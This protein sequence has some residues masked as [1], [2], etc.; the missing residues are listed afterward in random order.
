MASSSSSSSEK[1]D[2]FISFRG[3]D[4]R[5]GLTSFLY[6][7]LRNK[8]IQAYMDVR[9]FET[10]DEISP[11]L[12][13]A[14]KSSKISVVIFSENYASSTWCLNELVQILECQKTNRQIVVPVFYKIDAFMVREQTESYAV[15]F[16]KH[17]ERFKDDIEKVNQ[18]RKALKDATYLH[19]LDSKEYRSGPMLVQKIVD[20]IWLQLPKKQISNYH[21]KGLFGIEERVNKIQRLLSIG[22]TD[23]RII[24]ICGMGGIGSTF[25]GDRFRRKKVLIVLDDVDSS[26]NFEAIIKGYE[27]VAPGSRIIVTSRDAHVLRNV[28]KQIYEVRE[29]DGYESLHLFDLHAFKKERP[30]ED[31]EML[32]ARKRRHILG[33]AFCVI[34][35]RSKI[36]PYTFVDMHYQIDDGQA[37]KLFDRYVNLGELETNSDHILMWYNLKYVNGRNWISSCKDVDVAE[38]CFHVCPSFYDRRLRRCVDLGCDDGRCM[39]KKCGIRLVYKKD[40]EQLAHSYEKGCDVDDESH[41]TIGKK[42]EPGDQSLTH[43]GS[44][45]KPHTVNCTVVKLGT[46]SVGKEPEPGDQSLT[47]PGSLTKPQTVGSTVVKLRTISIGN[48]P[49]PGDQSLPLRGVDLIGK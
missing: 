43:L 1:H 18:W 7:A 46:I 27:E 39:I 5:D 13:N 26:T 29:L 32:S 3:V 20:D 14:I 16:E 25:I 44:L 24:G 2:V 42:P 31:F 37:H 33:V 21:Y 15:A 36:E 28:T 10:G 30:A 41:P 38:V 34:I 11:A 9:E 8:A 47:Y 23:S 48:E 45:T 6:E 17:E 4:T 22:S 49:E 12:M 40:L 19:G 35:D